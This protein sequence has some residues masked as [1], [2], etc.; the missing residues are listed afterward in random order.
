M[1]KRFN[2]AYRVFDMLGQHIA[3]ETFSVALPSVLSL[4]FPDEST[5]DD[6]SGENVTAHHRKAAAADVDVTKSF[7]STHWSGDSDLED[8]RI[9]VQTSVTKT[10]GLKATGDLMVFNAFQLITFHSR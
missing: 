2:D 9:W 10:T 7:L 8:T 3:E 1:K 5:G 6:D 4:H